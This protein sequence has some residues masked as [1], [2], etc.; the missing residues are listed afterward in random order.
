MKRKYPLSIFLIG[1]IIELIKRWYFPLLALFF[2]IIPNISAVIPTILL[3]IWVILGVVT[4]LIYVFM[5]INMD[6]DDESLDRMLMDN[7]RGY[8]NIVDEVLDIMKNKRD[9][10]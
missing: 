1:I 6:P 5:F 4:Q 9:S 7:G 3:S 8:E 2:T 10:D